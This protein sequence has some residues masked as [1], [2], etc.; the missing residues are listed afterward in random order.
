MVID[1]RAL[2]KLTVK[3]R[4][5][6]PNIDDLFDKLHGA[7]YFS[8][9]DAA[10]GFHQILLK[11]E[12]RPKTAFRT[13]FGH[14]QFRVLPFGLTN[15]PATFQAVMNSLFNQTKYNADST[16][17]PMHRLSEFVL[18]FIDDILIFSKTA[19]E[20]CKHIEIVL[21]LLRQH[22]VLIKPSKCVWGQTELPYLGHIVGQDGIKPDPQKV[23]DVVDWPRLT[24]VKEVQQFRG[25]TNFF[26]RY[27]QG[28]SQL[29]APLTDLTRKHVPFVW[30]RLCAGA[31]DGLKTALSTAPVLALPDPKLPYELVTDSCGYGVGAVLMQEEKPVAYYSQKMNQAERNY[32]NHEQELLA[33]I[34]ALKVFRCYL[35]SAHFTLVTDNMPNTHLAT[36]PTLFRR[37]ARWSEYLQRYKSQAWQTHCG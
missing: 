29:T 31:F 22:K 1:Y 30:D 37:Q 15:A 18:V 19:E 28:Y 20:H 17:N 5:P 8:S 9:L 27:V 34:A 14:Y 26:R 6:L 33:V 36:Q 13:P 25:L 12:D 11:N 10:S 4:Y 35:Q 16:E 24:S 32:V 21:Q 3:N 7:K 2:N 23:Q